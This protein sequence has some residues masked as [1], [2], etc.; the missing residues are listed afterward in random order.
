[1]NSE[2]DSL[3][4][5]DYRKGTEKLLES[6]QMR[7]RKEVGGLRRSDVGDEGEI[8]YVRIELDAPIPAPRYPSLSNGVKVVIGRTL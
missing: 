5:E 7:V 2:I 4:V 8:M 1:M 6:D 3:S